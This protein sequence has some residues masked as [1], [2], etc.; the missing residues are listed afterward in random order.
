MTPQQLA[1]QLWDQKILLV[2][3]FPDKKPAVPY[4][5]WRETYPTKEEYF[6]IWEAW[7]ELNEA[8]VLTGLGM[9]EVFDVDL[10]NDP[11][12]RIVE[13]FE[14]EIR[15]YSPDLFA[16]LYIEETPSGGRHY[17]YKREK[18]GPKRIIA[19]V[20]DP[21]AVRTFQEE[22]DEVKKYKAVIEI[23]GSNALCRVWPTKGFKAIQGSILDVPVLHENDVALLEYI[24]REF[25]KKPPETVKA[26]ARKERIDGDT[27]GNDYANN[28]TT[29]DMV[30]LFVKHGWE[31]KERGARVFLRRPGAKTKG[32]DGDIKNRIFMN[33]SS[34]VS[35]FSIGQGYGPFQVYTILEHGGDFK[36]AARALVADG[37]GVSH[38]LVVGAQKATSATQSAV[39]KPAEPEL[40]DKLVATRI[41][42]ATPPKK[43]NYSFKY[44]FDNTDYGLASKGGLVLLS[45]IQKARKTS[46]MTS[47]IAAGIRGGTVSRFMLDLEPGQE[48][49]IL[50]TEQAEMDAFN[51]AR[52][53]LIQSMIDEFPDWVHFYSAKGFDVKERLSLIDMIFEKHPNI[54]ILVID[55]LVDLVDDFNDNR[56]VK[57]TGDWLLRKCA[58]IMLIGLMHVNRGAGQANG[59][60]GAYFEKK[61]SAHIKVMLNDDDTSEVTFPD[62]RGGP[63][64]NPF[65]FGVVG[66]NIPVVDGDP[67]PN[68]DFSIGNPDYHKQYF[69]EEPEPKPTA[70]PPMP[71]PR[72]EPSD[73]LWLEPNDL[74]LTK[75]EVDDLY[76]S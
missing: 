64:P 57:R 37:Y 55:G 24:G 67:R 10:K 35:E 27:P 46:L 56:E 29:K 58:N 14:A 68:Y 2:P 5:H 59:H 20:E 74:G 33:F 66:C 38:E 28:V 7:K 16:R 26:E 3:A 47:M 4:A 6:A 42:M 48:M 8:H 17:A 72:Q 49:V 65:S 50:D 1:N 69:P 75:E 13:D 9:I 44:R 71:M 34:S 21:H 41:R 63:R 45:G 53:I 23:Q 52:R 25:D 19:Q 22:L 32:Y 11:S 73:D 43:R 12:G 39:A 54:A 18:I 51:T 15:E 76:G 30:E 62:V 70:P 31:F 36:A 40:W 61:C 60:L